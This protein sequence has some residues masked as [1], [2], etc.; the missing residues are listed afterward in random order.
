MRGIGVFLL[1]SSIVLVTFSKSIIALE[2]N[3][4]K[5]YI[6]SVLCE[7]RS[8]PMMHC[9]GKCHLN[10]T[11]K[12]DDQKD[13]APNTLKNTLDV[14]LFSLAADPFIFNRDNHSI[15]FSLY[16]STAYIAPCFSIFHPPK[17]A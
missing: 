3:L 17:T 16:K 11:M 12:S 15:A 7:N 4:N 10:K 14:Q 6:S 5:K 2:Y 13:N 1:I 8:K 9:N